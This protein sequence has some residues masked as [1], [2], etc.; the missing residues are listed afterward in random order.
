MKETLRYQNLGLYLRMM[1][2]L[3]PY[4]LVFVISLISM[5]LA[6]STEP[7]FTTLMKPLVDKGFV[8]K[9]NSTIAW[10]PMAIVVLFLVRGVTS[11]INE[12]ATSWLAGKLVLS[13]RKEMFERLVR[14][15][16]SFYQNNQSAHLIS[17]M[18]YDSGLVTDAG[19]NVITVTIKDGIQVVGLI[20]VMFYTDWQL[21]LICLTVFPMVAV[22]I[23]VVSKRLRRLSTLGQ[24]QMA[25]MTQ[26]LSEVIDCE[27]VVKI[28]GG[29][30]REIARFDA[31]AQSIRR[32][33][34]KQTAAISSNTSVTQFIIALALS[35]ILYFA[36]MRAQQNVLTAGAFM[37]FLTSM[38]MLFAPIKRITNIS[39]SLQRGLSAAESVFSFLD[40]NIEEDD[41]RVAIKSVV[42][43]LE[44]DQVSFSYLNAERQA[45]RNVS[46]TV[47]P[48]ETVALVGAS[49]SGKTTLASLIP[50]FYSPTSG[51]IRLDGIALNELIL[52]DLRSH[53]ALV[54]QE[55]LLFNDTV[56]ANIAYSRQGEVSEE[57]IVAAA[58]A[59]NAMEFIENLPDGLNTVIGENGSSLSGGQRQ[60]LAIARAILKNA[61]ILILDEATSALDTQSERLVQGALDKLMM[62]RTTLVIAHRLSTIENA[63]RIV[64]MN[65]GEVAEIGTHASLIARD[66]IY[67][68]LHRLQFKDIP[69]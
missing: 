61:P 60:R 47:Q 69:S 55:V 22:C 11:F 7:A 5:S 28:Y 17:K 45:L 29:E 56:A 24:Q 66:G 12:Y 57:D 27:K 30:E 50:R 44:F 37:T 26:V 46:F 10:V 39:Q 2:Y 3:K 35:F 58:R 41:G 6:A 1:K 16:V 64:V 63:D 15:P 38:T 59:A 23:R 52:T 49:G 68:N 43:H 32:N 51:V 20:G 14:M 65:Q 13:L 31:A 18:T 67:A 8:D 21:S 48:G 42:G 25:T 34:I 19:F 40:Q 54:S 4:W 53:I 33:F 36:T 9:D 62:N